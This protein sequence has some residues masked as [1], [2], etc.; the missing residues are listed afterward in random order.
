[1]ASNAEELIADSTL[2]YLE[3]RKD[4]QHDDHLGWQIPLDFAD[5]SKPDEDESMIVTQLDAA[6]E[7]TQINQDFIDVEGLDS[8]I[9]HTAGPTKVEPESVTSFNSNH[10]SE[11][12]SSARVH[13]SGKVAGAGGIFRG[14]RGQA[15]RYTEPTEMDDDD[16]DVSDQGAR[17]G[18]FAISRH[19]R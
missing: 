7:Q 6:P 3:P 18:L 13:E 4:S 2:T 17:Y 16:S 12:S 9:G 8:D 15:P 5:V 14:L 1:M 19:A 10:S 11:T